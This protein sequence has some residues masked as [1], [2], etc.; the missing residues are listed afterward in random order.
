[1]KCGAGDQL[2]RSCEN[3][4]VLLRVKA[5]RQSNWI[6][7]IW[8]RNCRLKHVIEGK[9]QERIEV[10]GRRWKQLLDDLKEMRG[11]FKVKEEA[12]HTLW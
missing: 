7:H 1:L 5:E 2:D 11:Y 8:R 9:I 3:E 10:T 12:L 6:G 4:E